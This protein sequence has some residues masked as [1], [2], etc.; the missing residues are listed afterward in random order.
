MS[1]LVDYTHYGGFQSYGYKFILI[2]NSVLNPFPLL[3]L[4]QLIIILKMLIKISQIIRK[5]MLNILKIRIDGHQCIKQ[6]LLIQLNLR[7]IISLL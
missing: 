3:N 2:I 1:N 7:I 5:E 6:M 4:E